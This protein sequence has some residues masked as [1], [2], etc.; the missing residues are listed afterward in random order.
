MKILGIMS[1]SSLDGVDLAV[2]EF[3]DEGKTYKLKSC[4][5]IP[6]SQKI[7]SLLRGIKERNLKEYF[8]AE[9]QYSVELANMIN[10]YLNDENIRPDY[11][12]IHGH[13]LMHHPELG[14]SIQMG[15]AAQISVLTGIDTISDFRNQDIALGGQGAPL[16]SILE[17]DLF[18]TYKLFLNLGGIANISYH[19]SKSDIISYDVCAC[20]QVLNYYSNRL[21][22]A[23]DDLGNHAKNGKQLDDL[24]IYL[25]SQSYFEKSYPKSLDNQYVYE[26]FIYPIPEL[27]PEEDVLHT[28]CIHIAN[29]I[30]LAC[31]KMN[32][33]TSEMLISGGGAYNDFLVSEIRKKV[34]PLGIN[35][36]IPDKEIIDYKESL[37]MAYLAY[38]NLNGGE[39]TVKSA[40]G[41]RKEVIAG[42]HYKGNLS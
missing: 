20:N 16:V 12:S 35:I 13:T 7:E 33:E 39:N 31:L 32:V 11:I 10:G 6:Y 40:T 37:L 36:V 30:G 4:R 34:A 14:F 1:G 8:T 41:A 17:R 15:S 5:T 25:D 2:V 29:Q 42:G 28:F 26:N 21:G 9:Q 23:Y 3:G 38:Q 27:I 22:K 19:M 24:L 18:P